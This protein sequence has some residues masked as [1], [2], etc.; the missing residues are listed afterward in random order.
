[1]FQ[2]HPHPHDEPKPV[3]K[4]DPRLAGIPMNE[5]IFVLSARDIL[6]PVLVRHW[7]A[8]NMLNPNVNQRA[9]AA[10][11][12]LARQ[13]EEWPNRSWPEAVIVTATQKDSSAG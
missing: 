5:P 2:Q 12:V 11:A 8:I 13:M 6:A 3:F 9:L 4:E 1:M 10:A 7:I